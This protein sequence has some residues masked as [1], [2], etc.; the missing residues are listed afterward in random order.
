[1]IKPSPSSTNSGALT[2]TACGGVLPSGGKPGLCPKC[3]F[4]I[5]CGDETEALGDLE[6]GMPDEEV[7]W[8]RLGD[9]DLYDEI[10]HGGMGIVYRARQRRLGRVVAVKVL[11]GGELADKEARLRFRMEA[12]AAG[13]LQHPGVVAIFDVG[14]DHG[15]CWFSMEYVPG[16]NLAQRVRDHPLEAMEAA[17]C[18]ERISSAIQHAHDHQILHRDLK[19]SNILMGVE[20]RPMVTDFGLARKLES[21]NNQ[22]AAAGG[23]SLTRTGQTLGSP[24][25]VSPEQALYGEADPRSDVYGLGAVLYHSLT[26]RAPFVG[27]TLDSILLQLRE[28]EPVPP[29]RLNPTVPRD[30]E[31]ICLKCLEKSPQ[32]RYA[33]A[34][35]VA[36]DLKRFQNGQHLEARPVSAWGKVVRW[37]RHRPGVAG[38]VA[39]LLVAAVSGTLGI[40]HQWKRAEST[41]VQ[42]NR[43]RMQA[44]A[45]ERSARLRHYAANM[46]AAS[47]ALLAEDTG[48][49]RRLLES[50]MP[51]NGGEDF[52]GPEWHWLKHRTESQDTAVLEGHPWIVACLA[53]SPDGRWIASGGRFVNGWADE[54]TTLYI[55][56]PAQRRRVHDFP[57]NMGSVKSVQFTPDGMRL[58]AVS[59]AKARF[60]RTG[61]WEETGPL[62]PAVFANFA[63]SHPWMAVIDPGNGGQVVIY[64]TGTGQEIRRPGVG[65]AAC[66]FLP[67]DRFIAVMGPRGG[68]KVVD[69]EGQ[70]PPKDYPTPQ[71]LN[72]IAISPNGR[73]LGAVGGPEPLV[74]DLSLPQGHAPRRF[75]GHKLDVKGLM[76]TSDS[77]RLIT[78]GSDRTIRYWSV[79]DGLPAGTMRGHR[80]EVWC[81]ALDPDGKWLVTGSKDTTVRLWPPSPPPDPVWPEQATI[82]PVLWSSDSKRMLLMHE[83]GTTVIADP[84][85]HAIS[86]SLPQWA[87]APAPDGQWVRLLVNPA[88]LQ[89]FDDTGSVIRVQLLEGNPMPF[90]D[91][92]RKV[93]S[94]DGSRFSLVLPERQ[95]GVW[96]TATGKTVGIFP[97]PAGGNWLPAVFSADGRQLALAGS[98]AAMVRLYKPETGEMRDLTGH[99]APITSLAFSPDGK[100]L[101]SGG[102]DATIRLWNTATGALQAV[103]RGHIQ[104]VDCLQYSPDGRT[105]ASLGNFEALRLWNVETGSEVGTMPMPHGASWLG[106]SPD[107]SWLTVNQGDLR[108]PGNFELDRVVL[109]STGPRALKATP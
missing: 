22:Y 42:E 72:A 107:G 58:M 88:R 87:D 102:L 104:D 12:E 109:F 84:V 55:W 78:T 80:D 18:L 35:A 32:R 53:V 66:M 86:N 2:C 15:V 13:K 21:L 16:K 38:L 67:D 79:E 101:A 3:L 29:R 95:V 81:A 20:D 59:A 54:Q 4:L 28:T 56:D 82:R 23:G 40:F 71:L 37:C 11:R 49:A 96:D 62:V 97:R 24:G 14:E 52:R 63:H 90:K 75:S 45:S 108:E 69:L 68:V 19:P 76:F 85:T 100:Q 73:W 105:L 57:V 60:F 41:A 44:L 9:Y 10:A 92:E 89:Y 25:Y 48:Q 6:P 27:P 77:Q 8:A 106:F 43:Q 65:G 93:W 64:D 17:R 30:L 26:G 50:S 99:L 39:A 1:M 31:T 83:D 94:Q 47:Q 36:A 61:T 51:V 91:L 46:Y 70:A 98:S 103:L 7:P 74:W 33:S 5:S 34:A